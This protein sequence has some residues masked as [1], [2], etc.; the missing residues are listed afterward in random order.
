MEYRKIGTSDLNV[1]VVTF[2][3]WA[4]GGWMWGG[5]ERKD[6]VQA[7][8]ASYDLGVTS[9]DTAPIYGQGTSEE[10]VGE[11]IKDLPRDKVQILTKYGMRWD[12]EKG[13]LAMKSKDNSGKD[14][15]I[16]KYAGRDSIIKECEDSLR[17]LKTDYI[18]LYQIH[19]PDP[20]TPIEET[21]ET[22]AQLI[23]EGKVRYAGV[24]NYNVAQ[25][26]E[27]EKYVKLVSNQVPYSMV[28]RNIEADVVPYCIENNKSVLAYS[29]LERGLLTGKM[30]PGHQ[31]SEGD[32][33][34]NIYFFQDE[35][36]KRTNEFLQKIKPLADDK[37]ASLAQLVIRWTVEQ[38]GIT[39]ALVGAR[40]AEQAI[41]NA[42]ALSVKLSQD[43]IRF[44][45]EELNKLELVKPEKV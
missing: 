7:I 8:R 29:P 37:N 28:K 43:E 16:Y 11:A 23:K 38:P 18:D 27:A 2:G 21:M 25:M 5:T 12:L 30:K 34:T 10:I 44:I 9:I 6:A 13:E 24:C 36:L 26:Q 33:R 32:H 45:M 39:I 3:A 4:A 17:R 22:V 35:N 31:F 14:I 19:W 1:S 15:D 20:T 41:Q 42:K 40:N